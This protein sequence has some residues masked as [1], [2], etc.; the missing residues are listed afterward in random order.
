LNE[1]ENTCETKK[2]TKKSD[3]TNVVSLT[4]QED[5]KRPKINL[6]IGMTVNV[7]LQSDFDD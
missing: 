4:F 3:P 2:G 1:I 6:L 5:A 7:Q